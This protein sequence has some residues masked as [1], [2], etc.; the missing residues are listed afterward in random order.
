MSGCLPPAPVVFDYATWAVRF[1]NFSQTVGNG[2]ATLYFNEAS[3][4]CDNSPCSAIYD[5]NIR[6]VIL[7][8]LTAHIAQLNTGQNG[9]PTNP[10]MLVGRIDSATQ[11]S[12]SVSADM[13]APGPAG[14][15]VNWYNQTPYGA[16]AWVLMAP[17]R[18]GGRYTPGAVPYFGYR[19]GNG[20]YG[21]GNIGPYQ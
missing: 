5:V 7:N 15:T 1:P 11:G 12:V 21:Q 6:A 16:Q 20:G 9:S 17:F 3:I 2:L 14:G 10:S 8:L 19:R 13:G 4:Y 18:L